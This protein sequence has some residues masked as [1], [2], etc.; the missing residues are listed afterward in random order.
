MWAHDMPLLEALANIC[1]SFFFFL[2][3]W[4]VA[5]HESW[6]HDTSFQCQL[7]FWKQKCHRKLDIR[8]EVWSNSHIIMGLKFLQRLGSELGHYSSGEINLYCAT[9]K[10]I[11][12]TYLPTDITEHLHRNCCFMVC[13]CPLYVLMAD[14]GPKHS[15]SLTCHYASQAWKPIKQ[16]SSNYI[17]SERKC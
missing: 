4:S 1:S 11:F 3:K 12:S 16:F 15:V 14:R 10:A 8:R 6:C 9:C 2:K 17:L 5:V 13:P 7:E